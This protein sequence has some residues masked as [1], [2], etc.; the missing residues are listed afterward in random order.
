MNGGKNEKMKN[1]IV[2]VGILVMAFTVLAVSS[3]A[4]L[5]IPP[6]KDAIVWLEPDPS[7]GPYGMDLT[8]QL[9]VN[10]SV[11][12]AGWA[13]WVYFNPNCVN[14]TD[15]DFT[16]APFT[17]GA[18]FWHFGDYVKVAGLDPNFCEQQ[19]GEILLITFTLQCNS[20]NACT[21]QLYH[22]NVEMFDCTLTQLEDKAVWIHGNFTCEAESETFTKGLEEGWNLVSLPL[23]ASDMT[24]GSVFSS[25]AD[26]TIY[27]Y[28]AGTNNFM[29]L[30]E[31]DE[32][33]NG[34]GYFIN[35]TS[36]GTWTYEGGAYAMMNEP[37]SQGLN[38]IGWLN[39]TKDI[40]DALSSI[41][42]KYRYVARWDAQ[43]QNYEVYVPG[44][45]SAFNDFDTMEQG[46]GYFI[47]MKVDGETISEDC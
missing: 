30:S 8:V 32:L 2:L 13:D 20:T 4:A 25:V 37:L 23:V 29:V 12:L 7:S 3:A 21:S 14:I 34:V 17:D 43:T 33:E 6:G 47:S 16:G 11:Y 19:T 38:M 41:E 1:R 27:S 15:G 28:D 46:R 18:E 9:K 35:M 31:T 42:G 22:N 24:V 40:E 26:S 44:A 39:C 5:P 45:P 36:A 10:T